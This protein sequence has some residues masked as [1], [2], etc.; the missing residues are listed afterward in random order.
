M[1]GLRLFDGGD[2]GELTTELDGA[3]LV[4]SGV[5]VGV[6]IG[7]ASGVTLP[8]RTGLT[9]FSRTPD[10]AGSSAGPE[11]GPCLY[12]A[13]GPGSLMRRPRTAARGE[14]D[15]DEDGT[16]SSVRGTIAAWAAAMAVPTGSIARPGLPW[17]T[18]A[19]VFLRTEVLAGWEETDS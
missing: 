19:R 14:E 16:E 4:R 3:S 9:S 17:S 8:F 12:S 11:R 15:G 6:D 5:S 18:G 2:P 10:S 13:E 7:A 1:S